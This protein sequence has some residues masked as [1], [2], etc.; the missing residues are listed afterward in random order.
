[1]PYHMGATTARMM[2][3]RYEPRRPKDLGSQSVIAGKIR[4]M[5]YALEITGKLIENWKFAV[6]QPTVGSMLVA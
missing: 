2:M 4:E 5:S 3:G 1:M 6:C